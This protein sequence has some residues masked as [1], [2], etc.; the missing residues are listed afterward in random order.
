LAKADLTQWDSAYVHHIHLTA[1]GA[2]TI[3]LFSFTDLLMQSGSLSKTHLLAL[4]SFASNP[5]VPSAPNCPVTV[6]PAAS[7]PLQWFFNGTGAGSGITIKPNQTLVLTDTPG[8]AGF[9]VDATHRG[10]TFT[11]IGT[12]AVDVFVIIVGAH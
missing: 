9:T 5:A 1:S 7:N 3:D 2:A 10:W 12:D 4:Q 6:V 8:D 11:D